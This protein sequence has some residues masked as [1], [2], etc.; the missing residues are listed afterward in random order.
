MTNKPRIYLAAEDSVANQESVSGAL[1]KIARQLQNLGLTSTESGLPS[2]DELRR[3]A[4][5]IEALAAK[6]DG[7]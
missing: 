2:P 6:L 7:E 1:L 5:Q 4:A 3:I